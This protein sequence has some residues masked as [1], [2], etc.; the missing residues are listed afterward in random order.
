MLCLRTPIVIDLSIHINAPARYNMWMSIWADGTK[1]IVLGFSQLRGDPVPGQE[2]DRLVHISFWKFWSG[3][4][5]GFHT[6]DYKAIFVNPQSI[7]RRRYP[8]AMSFLSRQKS[9]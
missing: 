5:C 9:S 2:R 8:F 7:W 3:D 1:P 4:F 6:P